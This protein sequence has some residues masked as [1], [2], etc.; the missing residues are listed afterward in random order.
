MKRRITVILLAWLQNSII[1]DH[2][3]SFL[4]FSLSLSLFHSPYSTFFLSCFSLKWIDHVR[5]IH[6]HSSL[7]VS[8]YG[9][10]LLD[11]WLGVCVC[12]QV[13]VRERGKGGEPQR[14][15]LKWGTHR[16]TSR[17]RYTNISRVIVGATDDPWT[18]KQQFNTITMRV[19]VGL[20]G[21]VFPFLHY[22]SQTHNPPCS[23]FTRRRWCRRFLNLKKKENK[24]YFSKRSILIV[25]KLQWFWFR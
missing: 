16:E 5:G 20:W 10:V 3:F 15:G 21:G 18:K 12:L 19:R 24:N 4:T 9:L 17:R 1:T 7:E 8:F 13:D 11:C 22:L 6:L 23:L 25:S 14:W 2:L